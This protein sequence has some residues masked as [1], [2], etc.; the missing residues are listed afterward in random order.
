LDQ[1]QIVRSHPSVHLSSRMHYK[2]T[3]E[4]AYPYFS[5]HCSHIIFGYI[6]TKTRY[7]F[8]I[9]EIHT[10]SF[11]I[12]KISVKK[13][14]SFPFK[15][16]YFAYYCERIF[17]FWFVGDLSYISTAEH[18]SRYLIHWGLLCPILCPHICTQIFT[19]SLCAIGIYHH[20]SLLF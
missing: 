4:N 17:A 15:Q 18:P 19:L 6:P 11:I 13:N 1:H 14:I 8:A 9:S 12:E 10:T 3:I 2:T 20:Y 7:V 16:I 5:I